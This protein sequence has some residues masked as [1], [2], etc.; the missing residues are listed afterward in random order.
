MALT[1]FCWLFLGF[2]ER[3]KLKFD[4]IQKIIGREET[5]IS[6]G[7]WK[8]AAL[9]GF[10]LC[11]HPYPFFVGKGFSVENEELEQKLYYHINDVF[12]L[13]ATVKYI[14]MFNSILSMTL[15]RSVKAKRVW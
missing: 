1:V 13:L 9:Y 15:W 14:Y 7:R 12:S 4:K 11:I 2:R 6:L 10:V 5:I 3:L 8:K